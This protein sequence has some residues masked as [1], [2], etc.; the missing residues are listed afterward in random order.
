MHPSSVIK[1]FKLAIGCFD[2]SLAADHYDTT[3]LKFFASICELLG[4]GELWL[5]SLTTFPVALA[6][7]PFTHVASSFHLVKGRLHT[8]SGSKACTCDL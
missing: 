5:V 7:F 6:R 4:S 8:G 1:A 3:E 2:I